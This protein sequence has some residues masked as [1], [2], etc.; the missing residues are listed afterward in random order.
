MNTFDDEIEE[1]MLI[2]CSWSSDCFHDNCCRFDNSLSMGSKNSFREVIGLIL[3]ES[4]GEITI[5]EE[6]QYYN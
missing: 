6:K 1:S 2:E 5:K 4:Y 3:A